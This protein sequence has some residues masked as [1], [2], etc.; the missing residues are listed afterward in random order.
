MGHQKRRG[1]SR[2]RRS[3]MRLGVPATALT[4]KD[5]GWETRISRQTTT[6]NIY[7][8]TKIC[9]VYCK[10]ALRTRTKEFPPLVLLIKAPAP[11]IIP[12]I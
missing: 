5:F 2:L 10:K 4:Y 3:N 7:E 8:I 9:G 11:L 12:L 1:S 6:L